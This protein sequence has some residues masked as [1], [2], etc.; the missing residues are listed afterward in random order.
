MDDL[1]TYVIHYTLKKRKSFQ[2]KQLD[3]LSFKNNLFVEA[4]DKENL[5]QEDLIKFDKNKIKLGQFSLENRY[6][7]CS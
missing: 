6:M 3:Y 1:I 7:Q 5:I 2:L 4:H